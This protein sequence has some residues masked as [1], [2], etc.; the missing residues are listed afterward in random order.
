[1]EPVITSILSGLTVAI[2]SGVVIAFL[3]RKWTK[4]DKKREADEQDLKI[5]KD[6]QKSVWRLNKTVLILAKILDDQTAKHHP[7]LTSSLEDIA[8]ELLRESD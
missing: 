2:I 6:L 4:I 1:M 5:I 8:S 7:E 3:R